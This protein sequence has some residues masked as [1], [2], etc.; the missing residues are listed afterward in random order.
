MLILWSIEVCSDEGSGLGPFEVSDVWA[1]SASRVLRLAP[2]AR[3]RR[4][5]IIAMWRFMNADTSQ[6]PHLEPRRPEGVAASRM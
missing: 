4:T 3:A 5:A 6:R 1:R 2:L